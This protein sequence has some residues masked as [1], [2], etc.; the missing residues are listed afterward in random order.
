MCILGPLVRARPRGP[1]RSNHYAYAALSDWLP[2][3]DLS[4]VRPEVARVWLVRRYLASFGPATAADVCWWTGFTARQTGAALD[5]L[6]RSL[7]EVSLEGS[8]G[9]YWM[10]SGDLAQLRA[11]VPPPSPY[12]SLLPALDPYAMGYAGR[13]RFLAPAHERHVLDRAGNAMPTA[14]VDGRIAGAWAQRGD[15]TVTYGLFEETSDA[16]RASLDA[17]AAR[18]EMF[19]G[20]ETLRSR[21]HTP[22]TRQLVS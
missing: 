2:G 14:W 15:G 7:T 19:L 18:L 1:W 22:F 12:T 10:L 4:N 16:A 3:I 13:G 20:G 5:A 17:E 8:E 11:F 21:S 9:T 6:S